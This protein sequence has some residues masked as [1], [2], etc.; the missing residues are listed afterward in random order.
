MEIKRE[1][2]PYDNLKSTV[3][4]NTYAALIWAGMNGDNETFCSLLSVLAP[5]TDTPFLINSLEHNPTACALLAKDTTSPQPF[6]TEANLV[7]AEDDVIF[8]YLALENTK[9]SWQHYLDKRASL[10]EQRI[11]LGKEKPLS[12]E[13]F[14][15]RKHIKNWIIYRQTCRIKTDTESLLYWILNECPREETIYTLFCTMAKALGEKGYATGNYYLITE[16]QFTKHLQIKEEVM[17]ARIQKVAHHFFR[18]E[19]QTETPILSA[20][21]EITP[22]LQKPCS[23]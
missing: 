14:T 21:P 1:F 15:Y 23:S 7:V 18:P 4:Q 2:N 11:I 5:N 20:K 6:I 12:E 17:H 19:V 9:P 8:E 13:A 3:I 10:F 16:Q 22:F